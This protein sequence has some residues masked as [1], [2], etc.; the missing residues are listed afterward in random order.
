[1]TIIHLGDSSFSEPKDAM[2]C[3]CD[4]ITEIANTMEAHNYATKHL[5]RVGTIEGSGG[6]EIQYRCP[7]TGLDWIM[8]FP[9]GHLQGG[10]PCI[11]RRMR[12]D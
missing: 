4:E 1:M 2:D 6:W 8:S 11:L 9:Q 5:H 3:R 12:P 7:A 10:G